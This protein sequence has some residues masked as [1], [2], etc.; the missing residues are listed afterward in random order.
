MQHFKDSGRTLKGRLSFWGSLRRED[1]PVLKFQ[2]K[3]RAFDPSKIR[4]VAR[5]CAHGCPQV[6]VCGPLFDGV[7]FPTLFWLTC[8]FLSRKC[9]VLES[10]H[11]IGELESLFEDLADEISAYHDK[12]RKLRLEIADGDELKKLKLQR[13]AIW[14]SV[15]YSGIGGID[16]ERNQFAVKC[17]HLQIA[18][19]LG[20]GYHPA[21]NWLS[22]N[23]GDLNC[24]GSLCSGCER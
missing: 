7:P 12:Y 11:K 24:K 16:T 2:N 20:M 10:E 6:L 5:R 15:A 1:F 3:A 21:E 22:S 14:E 8:P 9:G 19:W 23:I 18:T 13:P 4:Y 17:L